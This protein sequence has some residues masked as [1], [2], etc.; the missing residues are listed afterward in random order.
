MNDLK[1]ILN[2]KFGAAE[3]RVFLSPARIN[4]LG[5]HVDY[6]GGFVLPAAI[7]FSTKLAIRKN[8]INQYRIYSVHFNQEIE[9]KE[10]SYQTE[11]KW[12]NYVLGVVSELLKSGKNI[13]GFD[14]VIDG[15]IPQGAGLSSSASLEVGVGFAL[16]EIFKLDLKKEEI[17][18]LGQKAENNF[19][20]MNCGIMDQFIIAVG[21]KDHC[22]LLNTETLEYSHE[23]ISI[24]ENE[25]YLINSNVKH[26][27]ETSAYN[28]RRKECESA[29]QKLQKLIPS[30]KNLYSLT[31]DDFEKFKS[32]L[33]QNEIK[34]VTHVVTEK[35]RTKILLDSFS[36]AEY[37]KAGEQIFETHNSL[38]K[39]FDVS[40]EETDF[41]VDELKKESVL[42]AR[43]IGGGFGGSILVLD[44]KG[45]MASYKDTLAKKYKD[46]FNLNIEFFQFQISEGVREIS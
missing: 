2:Q 34:R 29:L 9:L 39:N 35:L 16:S 24:G 23:T 43:M 26:S 42:G 21:K 33:T 3:S 18:V 44:K 19:V 40:C 7:N 20:G 6:L 22:I 11:K 13:S 4:I 45:R 27:L 31:M 28:E 36:K 37:T 14:L 8:Q 12:A 1:E 10:I 15:D 38:S 5:E 32:S 30:L 41:I 25:F 46:K 17:A